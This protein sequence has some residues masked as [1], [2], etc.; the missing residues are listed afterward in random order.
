MKFQK[1]FFWEH[2]G[3]PPGKKYQKTLYWV[4]TNIQY[5]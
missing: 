5:I 4:R 1:Y 2:G 3:V